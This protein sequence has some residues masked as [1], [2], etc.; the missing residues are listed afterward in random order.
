MRKISK[1]TMI[2]SV[3][4]CLLPMIAGAIVYSRLPEQIAVHWDINNVPDNYASKALTLFG[5][6]VFGAIVQVIV[7]FSMY[8]AG[9]KGD[10]MPKLAVI[11]LWFIPVIYVCA[12]TL[13]ILWALGN[14]VDIGTIVSVLVGTVFI[15]IGNY[16]PKMSFANSSYVLSFP[17][18]SS[19]RSFRRCM[20]VLSVIFIAAGLA[21]L[22]SVI[23]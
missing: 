7:C 8:Q 12:Y 1:K 21:F 2:V 22:G 13:I 17:Q 14:A 5:L 15:I 18:F 19:E 4:V 23:F 3:A 20:R 16:F 10:T 6:P 9:K 11:A